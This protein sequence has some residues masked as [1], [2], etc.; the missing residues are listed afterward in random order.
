MGDPIDEEGKVI[1]EHTFLTFPSHFS[2]D[3]DFSLA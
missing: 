3:D 1:A 2:W